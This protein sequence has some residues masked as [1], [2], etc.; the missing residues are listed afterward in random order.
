MGPD[1]PPQICQSVLQADNEGSHRG[2]NKFLVEI[3]G[4]NFLTICS[5]ITHRFP[6]SLYAPNT[7]AFPWLDDQENLK[8]WQFGN[9]GYPMV[10]AGMLSFMKPAGCTTVCEWWSLLS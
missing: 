3:D 9:T 4:V 10:D 8:R 2:E 7:A 1:Q 5:T 6:I